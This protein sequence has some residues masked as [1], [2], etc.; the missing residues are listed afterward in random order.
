MTTTRSGPE[1]NDR[2]ARAEALLRDAPVPDGP[3]PDVIDRTRAAL[4]AAANRSTFIPFRWRKTMLTLLKITAAGVAAAAGLSYVAYVPRASATA[5]FAEVAQKLHDAHTLSYRL[6]IQMPGQ[7]APTPGREYYKDPG[8]VRSELDAPQAVVTIVDTN[9]GKILTLDPSSKI[10]LLQE[11]NLDGEQKRRLRDRAGNQVEYLRA[12]A[13]KEGK[14]VG[15]RR[16]GQ[17]EAQ[18]FQVESDGMSW[19][20]WVD[21]DRKMPLVMETTMRVQDQD[22]PSTMS[23]FQIDP[24]LDDSLFRLEAP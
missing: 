11:W 13:G 12:L 14:P 3:T 17:V 9:Q 23:D 21:A 22:F 20:V 6:S 5:T 7:K 8:L 1:P 16:I 4:H 19:T 15:E 2:L 18:G 24:K 10:A